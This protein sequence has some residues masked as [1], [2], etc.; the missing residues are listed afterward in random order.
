M[1][2]P[3]VCAHPSPCDPRALVGVRGLAQDDQVGRKQHSTRAS[4]AGT[5]GHGATSTPA[6]AQSAVPHT[7]T[8]SRGTALTVPS[9]SEGSGSSDDGSEPTPAARVTRS[10]ART[11]SHTP[12]STRTASREG[13]ARSDGDSESG[14]GKES[15]ADGDNSGSG[16]SSDDDGGG[17]SESGDG[18]RYNLRTQRDPVNPYNYSPRLERVCCVCLCVFVGGPSWY[19]V[20]AAAE[21]VRTPHPTRTGVTP[22]RA[23]PPSSYVRD[24]TAAERKE[25]R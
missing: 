8:R 9:T 6:P 24:T 11:A 19:G 3:R 14:S 20:C 7:R 18:G 16:G 13:S 10:R 21:P 25:R 4:R 17:A 15:G 5:G 12:E 2:H 1:E 22:P 23:S